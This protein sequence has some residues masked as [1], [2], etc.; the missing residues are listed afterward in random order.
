MHSLLSAPRYCRPEEGEVCTVSWP[1]ESWNAEDSEAFAGEEGTLCLVQALQSCR[2]L[3][4]PKAWAWFGSECG[5]L[6]GRAFAAACAS[7]ATVPSA[8][9]NSSQ[10][11]H[12]LFN[13]AS[14]K[15]IMLIYHT[16]PSIFDS[17]HWPAAV[18]PAE[19]GDGTGVGLWGAGKQWVSVVGLKWGWREL[20]SSS[21]PANLPVT[22]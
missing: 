13:S 15:F 16:V 11:E 21:G 10:P 1:G 12:S 9:L 17:G 4:V 18:R 14:H 6:W 19:E 5:Q 3:G 2:A 8:S 22:G 20:G 7:S